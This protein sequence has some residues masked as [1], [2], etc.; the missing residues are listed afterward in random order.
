MKHRSSKLDRKGFFKKYALDLFGFVDGV[1]GEELDSL[2]LRFPELIRPP[3][4]LAEKEFLE[5]CSK[6]GACVRACP[7]FAIKPVIQGNEFDRGTP[8]LRTGEA[9]CRFCNDTPC[10]SACKSG[11][12]SRNNEKKLTKIAQ[13]M[14]SPMACLRS[15]GQDCHAC[16]ETCSS[17][18]TAICLTDN[19]PAIDP[20]KCSGCGAC[21]CACPAY[22]ETAIR[23]IL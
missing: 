5:K 15:E 4:A 19:L 13:A 20:Q 1:L 18:K 8:S 14:V 11:A 21:L 12:L 22:P 16:I 23:L 9:W 17:I 2:A 6:C 7:F 3:G 10:I